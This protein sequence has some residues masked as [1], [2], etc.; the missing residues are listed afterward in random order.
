MSPKAAGLLEQSVPVFLEL[1]IVVWGHTIDANDFVALLKQ[2][3]G[4]VKPDK[5]RGSCNQAAHRFNLSVDSL[6]FRV[7][8]SDSITGMAAAGSFT[9]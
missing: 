4:Q 8:R 7:S 3:R 6:R 9:P 1:Y 2:A 5:A